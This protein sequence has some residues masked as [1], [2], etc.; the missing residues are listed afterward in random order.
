[1][2]TVCQALKINKVHY[3]TLMSCYF[4][5]MT[6]FSLFRP[7]SIETKLSHM[8]Y[9][10]EA[11]A[12][13]AGMFSFAARHA[14][15]REANGGEALDCPEPA[16][17]AQVAAAELRESIDRYGDV[18]PPFWLLQAY[19]LV[20]HYQLTRS[21]RSKSWR[22]LGACTRLAYDLNLHII[23][24]NYDPDRKDNA[25]RRD[26]QRWSALEERRRAWW[27]IWEMEVFA[28][29]IRQ[30]PPAIDGSLNLTLLPVSDSCW[31][32]N[33]FQESC[34]LVEDCS[35][36]WKKLVQSGNKSSKAWFIVMNSI[37]SNTQRIVY[38]SG[39][40]MKFVS[41]K[42][43]TNQ[44]EL[45]I[46]ANALYCT[47][48]SIPTELLYQGETLDFRQDTDHPS[49][50]NSWGSSPR[51]Q[52][53]DK[54]ALQTMT[55]L[56]RFMIYHHKICAHA[57]WLSKGSSKDSTAQVN[58]EWSNYMNASD[59]IV[60]VVRNSSRDH[61]KYV[62]PFLA[63]ILWFAAAAQCA[64]KVFGPATYNKRL[65]SS[66]LDLLK[67][68]IDQYIS[69]WDGI[70]NLKNKLARIEAR[71]KALMESPNGGVDGAHEARQESPTKAVSDGSAAQK[72]G[73]VTTYTTLDGPT[74]AP[75]QQPLMLPGMDANG[76]LGSDPSFV[77]DMYD[78]TQ[79]PMAGHE[80]FMTNPMTLSP[81]GLEELL[82]AGMAQHY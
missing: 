51:Q 24:A 74:S 52:H 48:T 16:Y 21:V 29:T 34:F 25:S 7:G 77:P 71:L 61:Y 39:S 13:V 53:A 43:E 81:F 63:N 72:M 33:T 67:L 50:N 27:A 58:S 4:A 56:S 40:A 47:I 37:M 5:N 54:Y 44:D 73:G 66:R 49:E 17:F 57:P 80:L 76:L 3:D 11:I 14:H 69:F 1:M 6:A 8:H 31:V 75:A 64:C 15:D 35:L 62:S 60:A 41:G 68:T 10:S 46:M 59:E 42:H 82:T 20:T 36:R 23:D 19:I 32:N 65:T 9:L 30:L 70:D 45:D 12:L 28:G 79:M 18:Q 55:Q 22:T 2:E 38:P 26:M 78:F